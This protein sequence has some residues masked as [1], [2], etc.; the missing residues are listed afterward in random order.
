MYQSKD[1]E[2]TSAYYKPEYEPD[3]LYAIEGTDLNNILN[4]LWIASESPDMWKD[5][6]DI[7]NR[8]Q[9]IL[10][11]AHKLEREDEHE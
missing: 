3:A 5:R 7:A 6:R 8:T 9:A 11:H 4:A 1:P 2:N 10:W